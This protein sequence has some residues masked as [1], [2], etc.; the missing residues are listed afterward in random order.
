MTIEKW[1]QILFFMILR[2]IQFFII[3]KFIIILYLF[4]LVV[5]LFY[6]CNS[7]LLPYWS[8]LFEFYCSLMYYNS[9]LSSIFFCSF[10][11]C[12]PSFY[13]PLK[14]NSCSFLWWSPSFLLPLIR[15]SFYPLCHHP[16]SYL[17]CGIWIVI[18]CPCKRIHI[19]LSVY[20]GILI[21]I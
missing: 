16:L 14:W 8:Y 9:P 21:Y 20:V 13:N 4:S 11:L 10:F 5:L 7:A 3:L 1:I 18:F 6:I 12:S 15:F 17:Q 2:Y 19:L